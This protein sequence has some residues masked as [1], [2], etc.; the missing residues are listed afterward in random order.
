MPMI[1]IM[2]TGMT[3]IMVTTGTIT[4]TTVM[5]KI[6]IITTITPTAMPGCSTAALIRPARRS[7]A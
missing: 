4:T 5:T 1:I 7:P 2:I 6:T 3:T